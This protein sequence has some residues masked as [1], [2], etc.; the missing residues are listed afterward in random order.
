MSRIADAVRLRATTARHRG[1]A[2][3]C[4]VCERSFDAFKDDRNRAGALCWRCGS[5]ERHRAQWLLLAELRP[6][7]LR[8]ARTL[9]HFSPEWCLRRRLR[10]RPG[11]RYVTA[12]LDPA[13]VDLEL[14]ITDLDLPDAAST[15][16]CARTS[17]STYATTQ[18]RC[19][20]CAASRRPEASASSWSRSR[21]TATA[22]YEDETITAAED[23]ERAFL[24]HDHVRLYAPD[25]R[26][27]LAA[28]GFEVEV[29]DVADEVGPERAAHHGLVASDLAFVC[30]P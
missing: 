9:L 2:V 27:R 18:P 30:R 11:L 29:V 26:E 5:H 19:A 1:D 16:C 28:A 8:E 6:Q 23:R 13:G 7:L 15:P 24:Q 20:S 25:I 22:T 3:R 4:P 21:W 14:D 10:T 12:D 17:S